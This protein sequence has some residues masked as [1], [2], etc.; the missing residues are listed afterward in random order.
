MTLTITQIY[1][2]FSV[3]DFTRKIEIKRLNSDGVTY[4]ADWQDIETL[5]GLKLLE[6]AVKSINFK[7]SNNNYSFGIVTTGNVNVLLNSKNGQFDDETNSSSVFRNFLRHKTLIRIRDG[8]VDSITDPSNPVDVYKTVF[9]GFI[10]ATATGTKVDDENLK[11][12]FQCIDLLSFL[13]K[14]YTISDMGTLTSTNLD[15]L[16]FEI[17]NRSEFTDFFS[18]ETGKIDAGYNIQNFDISQYEGQTTLFSLFEN[19]STGHSFFYVKEEVFYYRSIFEGL[20]P[21]SGTFVDFD[22]QDGTSYDF[23]DNVQYD[24]NKQVPLTINKNKL[25]KFA[26]Y[27]DGVANVF[28]R[29]NWTD[30][31]TVSFTAS[32]NIYNKGKTISIDGAID[33][34]ERQN[35]LNIIGNVSKIQRKEF[36]VTIPYFME[37]YIM[38]E[39][40]VESPSIIPDDA[41]VWGVSR[42]G[43]PD[44]W[45]KSLQADNI[46]NNATWLIR[47]VK[48]NNF[49][50]TLTLQEII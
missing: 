37:V 48:H 5:S 12:N 27:N 29:F 13:L 15:D 42:W 31:D 36:Q 4:E 6:N 25:I 26:S 21:D 32:P 50:T 47:E 14:Q 18:V 45:R 17:M 1:D 3:R 2:R 24:F 44:K 35:L 40:I 33:Q 41:F 43:G 20:V 46:P 16:I 49:K 30:D 23:Q 7:L 34:T 22:F 28:E 39:I 10:D 11:Q 9:Q 8:F 38:D 19:F